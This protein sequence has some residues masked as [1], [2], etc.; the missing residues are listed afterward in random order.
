MEPSQS[1]SP[2][3]EWTQ[4][5]LI[6]AKMQFFLDSL[7]FAQDNPADIV[8]DDHGQIDAIS[9][10]R[11]LA[12]F[13][14]ENPIQS[15]ILSYWLL[16]Y[17]SFIT[18][19]QF[20]LAL[21]KRFEM[22]RL[23]EGRTAQVIRLRSLSVLRGWIDK[24]S[25]DFQPEQIDLGS[26]AE[27]WM[28]KL[29][30][31][32][33]IVK[34][35]PAAMLASIARARTPK[36]KSG[37]TA[38]FRY[39]PK[40]LPPRADPFTLLDLDPLEIARQLSLVDFDLAS[41]IR[42]KELLNCAWTKK[43]KDITSPN[44]LKRI[45]FTARAS[46]FVHDSLLNAA[47]NELSAIAEVWISVLQHL[48][49]FSSL[50]CLTTILGGLRSL[51]RQRFEHVLSTLSTDHKAELAEMETLC[52]PDRYW[53]AGRHFIRQANPPCLPF[54]GIHLTDLTFLEDGQ[55]RIFGPN[56]INFKKLQRVG[57]ALKEF[58]Q[59]TQ[60]PYNFEEVPSIQRFLLGNEFFDSGA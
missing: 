40:A 46:L 17:R 14:G 53:V 37:L 22:A 8:L 39:T 48:K 38:P 45:Q 31:D 7:T 35:L 44:V 26:Y 42:P 47:E 56:L 51:P 34:S 32:S 50:N 4:D 23:S 55:S 1:A 15:D 27:K 43:D 60:M 9:I 12:D 16:V 25:D 18:P 19:L 3:D 30:A 6:D 58:F 36:N 29:S 5:P 41:R 57:Q 28:Q 21:R 59:Y 11:L 24:Y 10:S 20:L 33:T 49:S 54:F 52:S 13:T 2:P